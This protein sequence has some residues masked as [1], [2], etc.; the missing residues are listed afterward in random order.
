MPSNPAVQ[1]AIAELVDSLSDL[2]TDSIEVLTSTACKVV[3]GADFASVTLVHSDGSVDTLAPT[4]PVVASADQLQ[5]ELNEGPCVDAAT[6]DAMFVAEDLVNDERWP[7]YGPKV[8]AL[9]I[10]AQMG[11]DLHHPGRSRAALNLYAQQTWLFVDAVETAV[12]FASH[13]SL[14]LGY[15]NASDHF[16]RALASRSTIGQALGIV[17]ERYQVNEERAFQFMTRVSQDSNIKLREVAA[18]IVAGL[19]RRSSP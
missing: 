18:D 2:N 13:A 4:D 7:N 1:K 10:K 9:G 6:D 19:N 3:P 11:I 12:L 14:V 5:V 15:A 8:A 16:Q 17:M